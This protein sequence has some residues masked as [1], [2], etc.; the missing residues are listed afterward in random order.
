MTNWLLHMVKLFWNEML[1]FLVT[2]VDAKEFF[3]LAVGIFRTFLLMFEPSMGR[4]WVHSWGSLNRW[5]SLA[6]FLSSPLLIRRSQCSWL[7]TCESWILLLYVLRRPS[8]E[9]SRSSERLSRCAWFSSS[10]TLLVF[11]HPGT[12]PCLP[13]GCLWGY[14]NIRL[15]FQGVTN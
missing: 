10:F 6:N 13:A 14:S 8:W 12:L 11:F 5:P 7:L 15:V 9:H 2:F 1:W 3:C 4:S